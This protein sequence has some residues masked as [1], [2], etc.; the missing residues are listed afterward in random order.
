MNDLKVLGIKISSENLQN[1]MVAD[2]FKN[3]AR[4]AST[5]WPVILH[6]NFTI[7]RQLSSAFVN[8]LFHF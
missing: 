5:S 4:L 8:K 2:D 3:T 1:F 7:N 6:L